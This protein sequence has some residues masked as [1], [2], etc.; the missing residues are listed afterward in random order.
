MAREAVEFPAHLWAGRT[1]ADAQDPGGVGGWIS[2]LLSNVSVKPSIT[3]LTELQVRNT[4]TKAGV[5]VLGR[6]DQRINSAVEGKVGHGGMEGL[7]APGRQSDS[8]APSDGAAS[9][10]GEIRSQTKAEDFWCL[11]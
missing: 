1:A 5:A 9:L 10:P 7:R 3:L 6:A 4:V 2:W 8:D 11:S